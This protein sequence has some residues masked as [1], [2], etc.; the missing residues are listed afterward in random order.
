MVPD[1]CSVGS[2]VRKAELKNPAAGVEGA[3]CIK[4]RGY[5]VVEELRSGSDVCVLGGRRIRTFFGSRLVE[6]DRLERRFEVITGRGGSGDVG[7]S[8]GC[9]ENTT[10]VEL[11]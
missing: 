9:S 2:S 10:L 6:R 5:V 8:V 1:F 3:S 4:Y 7:G 11:S